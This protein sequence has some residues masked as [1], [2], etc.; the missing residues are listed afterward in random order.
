M[1]EALADLIDKLLIMD[2]KLRLNTV[3]ALQHS[4]FATELPKACLPAE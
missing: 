4:F 1:T 2:P 3:Q